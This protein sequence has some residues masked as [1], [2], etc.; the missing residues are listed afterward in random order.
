MKQ[1]QAAAL[2]YRITD[3]GA[4]GGILV[5]PLGFQ[6]GAKKIATAGGIH[7]VFMDENSTHTDYMIKFLDRATLGVSA[8]I[9]FN[10]LADEQATHTDDA[11]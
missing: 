5:S 8:A 7:E 4:S 6:E 9:R 1:E 11:E 10:V 3:T 2:A